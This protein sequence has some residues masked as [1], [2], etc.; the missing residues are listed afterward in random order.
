MR[1]LYLVNWIDPSTRL[2]IEHV[3]RRPGF[4]V[5]V[6]SDC[7][8]SRSQ[9]SAHVAAAPFQSRGKIDPTAIR[10]LRG[11]ILPGRF[12]VVHTMNSRFLANTLLALRRGQRPP[13]ICGFLGHVARFSRWNAIHRL[14][15]LHP[16]V[17]GVW[18]NC[19]ATAAPLARCGVPSEKLF[20]IYPGLPCHDRAAAV[21]P[22]VRREL[23]I[24]DD[25]VVVGFAGNMRRVK[26]V[27]VLLQAA[28]RLKHESAIHWLL[29][30]RIEDQRVERLVAHP[31]LRDRVHWLGWRD[32]APRLMPSIDIFTMP[33]RGEGFS[34]AIMEAMELQLC[35]VVTSVG[36]TP[37]L[38]RDGVDG[39]VVP[40]NDVS[41][42]ATAIGQLAG[43]PPRR[44][45]L[46]ASARERIKTQFSVPGM[47]EQLLE[48]YRKILE[49]SGRGADTAGMRKSVA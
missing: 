35:S 28:V 47:V 8:K 20:T 32:D 21:D 16:R 7:E 48:M 36:G 9:L 45:A 38:V 14:T 34:R 12:D 46:A 40:P 39:L 4:S 5:T 43:D 15:F 18:C 6:L 27:D 17:A 26:G 11:L 24:P 23:G 1:I 10:A 49:R 41:A 30:G 25:A 37:E 42:L 33:S 19:Q 2:L 3:A 44:A 13:A 22:S 31:D 29:L